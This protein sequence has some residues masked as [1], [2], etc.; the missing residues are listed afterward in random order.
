MN[1]S[2]LFAM[3]GAVVLLAAAA[4][5]A[6]ACKPVNGHFEATVVAPG[7]G[8]C[9]GVPGAFCTAGRVWGGIQGNYQFVMTGALPAGTIGGI[10]TALF[11]AGQSTIFMN[12]GSIV[13]G[14]DSGTLD[15]FGQG[16]FASLIAF[17]A[18]GAG[19]IRLRGLFDAGA[20]TTSGD[21]AGE[22][23]AA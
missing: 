3:A 2:L 15:V 16:G 22:F 7:S 5:A 13:Q 17:T 10:P 12:D 23:C 9:P 21:Y 14:T 19:Q 8:H 11:F 20:A 18:G 4:Q 6:P 1:R